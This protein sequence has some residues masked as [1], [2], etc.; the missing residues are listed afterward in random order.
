VILKLVNATPD[1]QSV[2]VQLDGLGSVKAGARAT[3]LTAE[4]LSD[5]NDFDRPDR[6]VP[7][8]WPVRIDGLRF[9][10]DLPRHSFLVIRVPTA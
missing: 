9:M 8:P 7:K 10:L 6:V 2:Q 1:L 5:V 4:Q 3:L